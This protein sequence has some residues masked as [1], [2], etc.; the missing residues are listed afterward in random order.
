MLRICSRFVFSFLIALTV[1]GASVRADAAPGSRSTPIPGPI[2]GQILRVVDGDTLEVEAFIWPD[3]R[4]VT[5]VR[6]DG[7]DTPELKSKCE[8]EQEL[9]IRA[10]DFVTSLLDRYGVE[11]RLVAVRHDKYAGRVVAAVT[12]SNGED[13]GGRLL[14]EGLARPY[15][16]NT[17][18]SWCSTVGAL[19][20]P[21]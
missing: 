18:P 4:V 13:L 7:I 21:H 16:G 2:R 17:K 14:L 5:S 20:V 1:C 9:A 3:H 10:K 8:Q 19:E 6:V 12:L 11:V 15:D